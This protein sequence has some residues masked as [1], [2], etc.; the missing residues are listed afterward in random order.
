[1]V[2]AII[3]GDVIHSTR[4]SIEHRDWLFKQITQVLKQLNKDY[5]IRSE[6]F[7]GDSFQCF[8]K[9]PADAL[10]IALIQKTFIRSLYPEDMFTGS[11]K[12]ESSNQNIIILPSGII[13]ARLAIGIGSVDL[14]SNKLASSGGRAFELSGQ[15]LDKMKSKK[16]SLAITTDDIFNDELR[17]EFVLLNAIIS[18]TTALQCEVIN[19]KLLGYTETEIAE[20]LNIMQSAVN[21]RSN[22]G[23]W[24]AIEAMIKRFEKIYSYEK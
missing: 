16:Q 8:I 20:K 15:L 24:N 18:K 3:T 4:M 14:L 2:H 5:G 10:K 23:N 9:K 12:T 13:D 21:Q 11:K 6:T 1:M 19:H 22:G 17:T 7:R